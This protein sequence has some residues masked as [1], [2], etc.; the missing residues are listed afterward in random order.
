MDFMMN[1]LETLGTIAFAVSGAIEA[2]KKQMDLLGVIVLGMVTAIGGGV[3]R[4]IVTGEIPPI[5]FQNPTQAKVAIVVSVVVFFLAMFLTRHDILT[6]VSWANAV[7]FISDA[8]GLAAFT[9]LGIRFVQERIGNDN[10]ALLLFVGVITGVGGGL[11]RDIFAGNV[12]YIFRKHI[13]ATASIF[14]A[15]MYLWLDKILSE[16]W[17]V[18][19]S[20]VCII[21]VRILASHFKWNL[22]R[23]EIL[24]KEK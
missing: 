21:V 16:L 24:E 8:M 22:P 11:L 18:F 6:N 15:L 4:D 2:M 19:F 1:F 14:G 5:A 3:I 23:V 7:L 10:F 17:A 12:P 13:Y 20:M 9:I